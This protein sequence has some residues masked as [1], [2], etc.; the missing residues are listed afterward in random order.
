MRVLFQWLQIHPTI[1]RVQVGGL[2][3]A[4]SDA[5]NASVQRPYF[6]TDI[7]LDVTA[8]NAQLAASPATS[9]ADFLSK[10]AAQLGTAISA[11]V[12]PQDPPPAPTLPE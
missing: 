2:G 5:D 11:T 6:P 9:I 7:D 10:A 4:T 12:A 1:N 3:V 8:L